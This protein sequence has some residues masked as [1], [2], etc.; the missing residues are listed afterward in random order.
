M[1]YKILSAARCT[2]FNQKSTRVRRNKDDSSTTANTI[3]E[4]KNH[5]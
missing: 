2:I 1:L 4:N 5:L 3:K